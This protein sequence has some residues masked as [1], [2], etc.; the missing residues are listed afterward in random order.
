MKR[1]KTLAGILGIYVPSGMHKFYLGEIGMGIFYFLTWWLIIPMLFCI[2]DGI[3]I[4]KMT[5]DKFDRI[6]NEPDE[7]YNDQ[8]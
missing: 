7:T 2:I 6:Y 5:D 1:N 8:S 3:R 4:L